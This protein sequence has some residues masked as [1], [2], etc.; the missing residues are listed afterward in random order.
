MIKEKIVVI[1]PGR[2]TYTASE[3]N[4]LSRFGAT[5]KSFIE[6]IDLFRKNDNLP[7]I[8]ALDSATRFSANLHLV[9]EHA[10]TL[11]YTC[12]M[13]DFLSIDSEKFEVVAVT[14]NSM[15][16]YLALACVKVLDTDGAYRLIQTMG[17]M[18]Q[19]NIIGGQ[20]IYPIVDDAWLPC[21]EKQKVIQEALE[22]IH[23]KN[24]A[25]IY[26]SIRLGGYVVLAGNESGLQQLQKMLPPVDNQFP[27]RLNK[28][29]AFH[30]SLMQGVS[31]KAFALL[32][33]SLFSPPTIPLIDGRGAIW[34]PYATQTKL[35]RDYTLGHQVVEPYDFTSAITVALKEFAP[36]R[37]VLLGPGS[38]LGGAL[39]QILAKLKWRG[40]HSKQDFSEHQKRDPFLLSMGLEVQRK[41]LTMTGV[42]L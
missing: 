18:M 21:S 32:P 7:S 6:K 29:A 16:W 23:G 26:V 22:S 15:G 31:E 1:C 12:A 25:E 39:G 41:N 34:Q 20:I 2:G 33:E 28:H 40:I 9:G 38:T 3:L 11:I 30:T 8:T 35:L 37:L 13:A 5:Q 10:S 14:G 17:S 42:V 4:Y 36:D 24:G 19:D 27:M